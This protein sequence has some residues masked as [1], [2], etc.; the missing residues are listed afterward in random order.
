[1]MNYL[2]ENRSSIHM[3]FDLKDYSKAKTMQFKQA[4]ELI[5]KI[6]YNWSHSKLVAHKIHSDSKQVL[7]YELQP[8]NDFFATIIKKTRRNAKMSVQIN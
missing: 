6:L 7:E 1:M 8:V 3:T 5:N 4:V 2:Q